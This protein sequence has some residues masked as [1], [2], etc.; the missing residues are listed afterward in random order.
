MNNWVSR[1]G[2]ANQWLR[3]FILLSARLLLA[4][5]FINSGLSKWNGWFDFDESK[6]T[7]FKY[8]FF[9][10]DPSR[11]G[12]L[13]LCDSETLS[14]SQ[15]SFG[16]WLAE[17]MAYVAAVTEVILPLFLIIGLL[18]RPAAAGLFGMTLF[19]QL[20][21]Y[22]DWEHF[23]NPAAWWMLV[24]LVLVSFGPGR[25]SIDELIKNR[26]FKQKGTV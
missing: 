16:L 19:I 12:A 3:E 17:S 9:C 2:V 25:I 18:S 1:I 7:L 24:A 14:Y 26:F 22:P 15:G 20:A 5:V 21:V 11:N 6:L 4:N 23:M 13:Q 10:P 8:E